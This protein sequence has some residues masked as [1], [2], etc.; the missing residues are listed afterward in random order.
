M[1]KDYS[2]S[3]LWINGS[4][5]YLEQLCAKSYVDAGH[6]T[7]L[8]TYEPTGCIPEGVEV[9][10]A[11]KILP[12][13]GFLLHSR[14]GSP[15]LH[16]DLFRYKLLENDGD[17]I[18]V[19]TD[20]YCVKKFEPVSG[21]FYGWE[22]DRHVNG[23]VLALPQDSDTLRELLAFTSDEFAVPPWLPR[24]KRE[25][26]ERAKDAGI[27]V[28]ASDMPWGSWGPHAVTYFLK[29][30]GE[31]KYALPRA[32]LYPFSFKDRVKMLRTST[33]PA[34]FLT[35]DTYSIHFYGRRMRPRLTREKDGIPRSKSL[36]GKLLKQHDI[37]PRLAPIPQ[38]KKIEA[39]RNTGQPSLTELADKYGSDKGSSKYRYTELYHMLFSPYREQP[40]N[41]LEMGLLIGGPEHGNDASRATG[42]LPSIRMWLE[43]F[44]KAHITGLDISDFSFF[45]NDR[46]D[47]VQ[48][49][50]DKRANITEAIVDR[51][52]FDIVIDD[53]SHAS[54]HQQNAF[55]EIFPKLAPGGLY[56]IED[57]RWQPKPYEVSGITKTAALFQSY[58]NERIFTH[59]DPDVAAAFDALRS[60]IS[61]VF[62][63]QAKYQKH[64]KD[65]VLVVHKA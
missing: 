20:A 48:C 58:L 2:C 35:D 39:V 54:H 64:R 50:M 52:A 61:G 45:E 16:S 12:L 60:Q 11:K 36:I 65:Q 53:A 18:W 25:E 47:F 59:T 56:I 40:I 31:V 51:R 7:I 38:K 8:Y 10:D 28:H 15:A 5:S 41:F 26:M 23:G 30:T 27:P 42:D 63:F 37:D 21:Y 55:L 22:S 44:P 4:L 19:D 17:T 6:H 62:I 33:D 43:Y 57:L 13:D 14:T 32:G 29:K 3:M 49:D 1:K 9:R 34:D 24:R 46:F